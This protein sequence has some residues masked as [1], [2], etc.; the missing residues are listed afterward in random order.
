[1]S[2]GGVLNWPHSESTQTPM[3]GGWEQSSQKT[4]STVPSLPPHPVLFQIHIESEGFLGRT[5]PS[6]QSNATA[7]A[8]PSCLSGGP[9]ADLRTGNHCTRSGR[10]ASRVGR[11]PMT[12]KML[13]D[14]R[15]KTKLQPGQLGAG[16][17]SQRQSQPEGSAKPSLNL[18]RT[19]SQAVVLKL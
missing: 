12:L 4:Q 13:P 18:E 11:D 2:T 9:S 7:Q 16:D 17:R 15:I 10:G 6:I 3:G 5:W 8:P 14:P 1:M 19:C